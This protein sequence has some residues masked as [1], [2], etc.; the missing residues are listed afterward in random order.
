MPGTGKLDE[1][2]E[3]LHAD[4]PDETRRRVRVRCRYSNV[5]QDAGHV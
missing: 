5:P 1:V 4:C 2:L 3:A